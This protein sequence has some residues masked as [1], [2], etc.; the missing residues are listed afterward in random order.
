MFEVQSAVNAALPQPPLVE[1][2][3]TVL[4][5]EWNDFAFLDFEWVLLNQVPQW[6]QGDRLRGAKI[7]KLSIAW[8]HKGVDIDVPLGDGTQTEAQVCEAIERTREEVR[9][10][11]HPMTLGPNPVVLKTA[12]ESKPVV[13]DEP[14]IVKFTVHGST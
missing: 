8:R 14:A 5:A 6:E 4:L 12:I 9:A 1:K 7:R 11:T 3:P 10:G 2:K 13:T